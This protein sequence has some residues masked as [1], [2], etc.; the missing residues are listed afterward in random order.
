MSKFSI[1]NQVNDSLIKDMI[2]LDK[3]VF[4]GEDIGAFDKCKEWVKINPDIYTVLMLD[5]KVIGYINFMPITDKAYQAIKQ[6]KLKDYE[7]TGSEIITYSSTKLLKCLFT[8]IVIK[9]E[10]QDTQA[11]IELWNGFINKLKT[12]KINISSIVIDC[13]SEMG[14]KFIKQHLNVK[15][16]I[17]SHNG[18]IYEGNI[19]EL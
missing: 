1:V 8:S 5:N 16:I 11:I 9:P 3:L 6:G 2:E 10:H 12:M 19:R 13:V 17:N 14:E 18:K 15:F 7:L 4:K